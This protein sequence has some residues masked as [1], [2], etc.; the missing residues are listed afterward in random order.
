MTIQTRNQAFLDYALETGWTEAAAFSVIAGRV[1]PNLTGIFA[2]W[3]AA[4][5][6]MQR[7]G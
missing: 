7:I 2:A 3:C 4:C 1:H 6:W 5:E